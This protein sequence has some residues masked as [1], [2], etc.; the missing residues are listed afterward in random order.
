MTKETKKEKVFVS[1]AWTDETHKKWVQELATELLKNSIDVILD[2]W[3]LK[4]G[5]DMYSFMERSINE[6][7][8]V[9]IICNEQYSIK[10]D[11]RDGGVGVESSI[12]SPEVYNDSTQEKFIPVFIEKDDGEF[13]VPT[14][15]KGRLGIDLVNRSLTQDKI[16]EIIKAIN[17]Q[18]AVKKPNV[19][20]DI[21]DPQGINEKINILNNN[22]NNNNNNKSM[23]EIIETVLENPFENWTYFD[24]HGEYIL[25]D[26]VNL[27]IVA[28]PFEK[29]R[30][31]NEEWATRHPDP[32]AFMYKYTIF[33][34]NTRIDEFYLVAVDGHREFLPLPKPNTNKIPLNSYL[35]ARAVNN[36]GSLNE[37]IE[38]SG[39]EVENT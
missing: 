22:N 32:S 3:E 16:Q 13:C 5:H 21:Q 9:L 15:L 29:R 7:K 10:A 4:I 31:F 11:K 25:K 6:S 1:Y 17:D 28:E 12:I 2:V 14:Y 35:K 27:K 8:K 38:R 36:C 37:Y 33:Y 34:N 18:P 20:N 30:E 19:N 23:E 24:E 39:L 26:D